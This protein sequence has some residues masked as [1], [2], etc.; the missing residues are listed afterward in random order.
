[1]L[2]P[3]KPK[4]IVFLFLFCLILL[5]PGG[6]A[7]SRD[8]S[9]LEKTEIQEKE[10]KKEESKKE[11]I[12]KETG[13]RLSEEIVVI[14]STP[15]EAPLASVTRLD[16]RQ[17]Q[18][19][20]TTELAE[21]L[22]QA[23]GVTVSL[24]GKN[25]FSL[26]LRGLESQ[27]LTL[28]IDGVPLYEPFFA[29]FDLKS[30]PASGLEAIQ[31]TSGAT[32][33]LYGPNVLGGVVNLITRR[34]A[35]ETFFRLQTS[36]GE[37]KT[38]AFSLEGAKLLGKIGASASV[39]YQHSD[40]FYYPDGNERKKRALSDYDRLNLNLKIIAYPGSS[41]ELFLSAG[42]YR[43]AFGLPPALFSVRPRYWRF[44]NSDR[45]FFSL[46][47]LHSP[48]PRFNFLW[49]LFLVKY[50]NSLEQY[51]DSSLTSLQALSTYRNDL[52]GL[53]SLGDYFPTEKFRLRAS[54]SWRQETARIQDNLSLPFQNYRHKTGS[55]GLE[56]QV[57]LKSG[58][59][60][61]TGMS[62]DRLRKADSSILIR[63]NPL[64]GTIFSPA[65]YFS[66]RFSLSLKSRF[67]TLHSL[68][69]SQVGN[70]ELTSETGR[71]MEAG[72]I[73]NRWLNFTLTI[74][75]NHFHNLIEAMRLADG[76]RRFRNVHEARIRGL[77]LQIKKSFQRFSLTLCGQFLDHNNETE[78]RPLDTL[79]SRQISL[80][81]TFEPAPALEI[82][83]SALAASRS[84]WYDFSSRQLLTLPAYEN[85]D[86]V[87]VYKRH[88]FELFLR[89]TNLLNKFFYTE[90]GFPWRARYFEAGFIFSL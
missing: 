71:A 49:R 28:L 56:S 42:L 8:Q 2:V 16:S 41:H 58:W 37:A 77:E 12:K 27:R 44:R 29:S 70:P 17:I 11:E 53:F 74:F 80:Q 5:L 7:Q 25:E 76:T 52:A 62:L 63:L 78:G 26:R 66:F 69:A 23:P 31:I 15:R 33:A 43:S 65:D 18:T 64:A 60:L 32:S 35:A 88:H 54:L 73:W 13:A 22:R 38:S 10:K 4:I 67:P 46:G 83:I 1:M 34:P 48:F 20:R 55:L 75:D 30:L 89:A 39:N 61:V 24:N 36:L 14:G 85:V 19:Q 3:L 79:P 6:L 59:K 81:A 87:L 86:L 84:F 21:I 47:G 51:R 57:S 9:S 50:N 68:Y 40:G 90:P 82:S 45:D 72:L